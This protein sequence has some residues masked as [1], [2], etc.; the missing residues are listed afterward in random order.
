MHL[1]GY[2]YCKSC[3]NSAADNGWMDGARL[4][5]FMRSASKNAASGSDKYCQCS[6][7]EKEAEAMSKNNGRCVRPGCGKP[8]AGVTCK[9]V[10]D[11]LTSFSTNKDCNGVVWH[12][13]T[14]K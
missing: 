12:T 5:L 6:L 14:L 13:W 8:A 4:A 9:V 2:W 7:S 1:G 3:Y 10:Q 11:Y